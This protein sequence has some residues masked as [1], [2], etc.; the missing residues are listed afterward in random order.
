MNYQEIDVRKKPFTSA[1]TLKLAKSFRY[2]YGIRGQKVVSY[3]LKKE[4]PSDEDLLKI[5][6]GRS[7]TLRAPCLSVDD[8]F[9][10]GFQK[11]LYQKLLK[12]K[13]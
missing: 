12:L 4:N 6:L 11:D 10:A 1:E 7:G 2:I 13:N 9:V 8:S 3:D 5:L